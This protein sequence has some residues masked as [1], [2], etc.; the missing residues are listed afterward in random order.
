MPLVDTPY[1]DGR[2]R[3][4]S[5]H[6][7]KTIPTFTNEEKEREFWETADSTDYVDWSKAEVVPFPKLRPSRLV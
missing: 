6:A 7:L 5:E 1:L 4:A 3:N 2:E